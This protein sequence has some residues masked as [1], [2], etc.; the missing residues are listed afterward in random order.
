MGTWLCRSGSPPHPEPSL[1]WVLHDDLVTSWCQ[2]A[3]SGLRRRGVC[4]VPRKKAV[5]GKARGD[6]PV[7][8]PSE[9]TPGPKGR[10]CGGE[11]ALVLFPQS[12]Q[13]IKP[14][15]VGG[16]AWMRLRLV[17][18]GTN[19]LPADEGLVPPKL[20]LPPC[21]CG[22]LRLCPPGQRCTHPAIC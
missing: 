6:G 17:G 14:K 16:E 4:P 11:E 2:A 1:P 19:L 3:H 18:S 15:S 22:G 8:S 13:K 7:L 12:P 21:F 5:P 9:L 10:L 20:P